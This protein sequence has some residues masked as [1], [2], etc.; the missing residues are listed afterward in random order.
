MELLTIVL[1]NSSLVTLN[2]MLAFA[3]TNS[4]FKYGCTLT[5]EDMGATARSPFLN[6]CDHVATGLKDCMVTVAVCTSLHPL[7]CMVIFIPGPLFSGGAVQVILLQWLVTG[8][9]VPSC[10]QTGGHVPSLTF[11]FVLSGCFRRVWFH[12]S[13]GTASGNRALTASRRKVIRMLSIIVVGF[14]LC[15]LPCYINH[16]FMFF[17]PAV[18]EKIPIAVWSFNFWLSHANSAINPLFYIVLNRR[19]RKAFLN[20]LTVLFAFP[21]RVVSHCMS[22]FT[23][24]PSAAMPSPRNEAP[25]QQNEGGRDI[26]G[27]RENSGRK[28]R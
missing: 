16:Y 26:M 3:L 13:S 5:P 22:Y 19:F 15:W 24:E 9:R 20:A 7:S 14:A 4:T 12:K 25:R 21:C 6:V 17:Q 27:R 18:F 1:H 10:K 28:C 2:M 23:E 11:G 8:H